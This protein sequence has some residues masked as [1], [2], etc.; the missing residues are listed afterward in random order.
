MFGLPPA[1]GTAFLNSPHDL[2]AGVPGLR[3]AGI[4]DVGQNVPHAFAQADGLVQAP[5]AVG[6]DVDPCLR[7]PLLDGAQAFH[8]LLAA[9]YAALELEVVEAVLFVQASAC[10]TSRSGVSIS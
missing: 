9:E 7:E 10:S 1:S 4:L 5:C 2:T 3:A 6:V 8:L